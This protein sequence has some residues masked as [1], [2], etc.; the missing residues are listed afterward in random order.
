MTSSSVTL[1][2]ALTISTPQF[3]I[4][5]EFPSGTING[6]A[7]TA[8]GSGGNSFYSCGFGSSLFIEVSSPFSP[9]NYCIDA[10][11]TY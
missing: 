4:G 1:S 2:P 9:L 10:M 6:P 5:A 11:I 8:A 7:V 3:C